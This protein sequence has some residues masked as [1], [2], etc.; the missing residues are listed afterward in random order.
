[1]V[2]KVDAL[3]AQREE[4]RIK[5]DLQMD[6]TCQKCGMTFT[7]ETNRSGQCVHF[8]KWSPWGLDKSGKKCEWE[9]FWTCCKSQTYEGPLNGVR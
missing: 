9:F 8:G 1:M 5:K 7:K 6:R 4:K 2:L 3:N